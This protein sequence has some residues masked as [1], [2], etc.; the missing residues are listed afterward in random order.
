MLRL[1]EGIKEPVGSI[2][3]C[4]SNSF[5]SVVGLGVPALGRLL[6]DALGF[7]GSTFLGW[8]GFGS[9]AS[10]KLSTA[11]APGGEMTSPLSSTGGLGFPASIGICVGSGSLGFRAKM[12]KI[13]P[14]KVR[15]DGATPAG[16]SI[17]VLLAG[18]SGVFGSAITYLYHF[19]LK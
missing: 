17:G 3:G 15:L 13:L 4:S 8:R 2:V 16:T 6:C 11:I 1:A 14:K 9:S 19:G 12:V 5:R 7:G 18:T 10:F